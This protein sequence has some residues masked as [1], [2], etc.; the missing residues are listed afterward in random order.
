MKMRILLSN[1][2]WTKGNFYGVRAGTRWPF[3]TQLP[4]GQHFPDY[5]PFPF[6]LAYSASLLR[7]NGF[8]VRLIDA[9][10]LGIDE[11][12]YLARVVEFKPDLIIQETSTPSINT[13]L[14]IAKKVYDSGT[15]KNIAFS[16]PHVSI[17][18]DNFL[19]CHSNV[20]FLLLSEYEMSALDLALTLDGSK[21]LDNVKGL[22][23]KKEDKICQNKTR[24]LLDDLDILPFPARDLL[25]MTNYRDYFCD[26]PQ[27]TAQIWASRGCP[28]GCIFC[29]WPEVMYNSR[30]YRVR[31]PVMVA[32]EMELI[33]KQYKPGSIFF[34][35]DTF[36][37]GK[38]RML[39]LSSE[40][41][42]RHIKTPWAVMARPDTSD[43]E[44]L[45]AL[46]IAGLR[47]IKYGIES[48]DQEILN[49]SGKSLKLEK[50]EETINITKKL[51]IK[52]HLTFTVGLVDETEQSARKTL[53]F[54]LRM[55]P[56][57]AQFS[58]CTPFPGT[59]YFDYAAQK[60]Y[61]DFKDFSDFDGAGKAVIRT[62]FLSSRDLE[63]ILLMMQAAWRKHKLIR[64]ITHLDFKAFLR[65]FKDPKIIL[66]KLSSVFRT[67]KIF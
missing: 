57:S 32:D 16:G 55:N 47:A 9:I 36:N 53:A 17:Y 38:D 3:L 2:P 18:H 10:A 35:D 14:E 52:I 66:K 42:A 59:K 6:Y 31:N 25:P 51:G 61:I 13:D 44:T 63:K 23:F 1:P 15:C 60:K 67:F 33:E 54:A 34:D 29:L 45:N 50:A 46:K 30:R 62:E 8:D 43:E 26:M 28:F 27:P 49:K 24:E 40:I 58:I 5:I 7:E 20:S 21:P 39:R 65:V 56:D 11:N 4:K 12:E 41:R 19:Q 37:I 48:G 64:I 22:I